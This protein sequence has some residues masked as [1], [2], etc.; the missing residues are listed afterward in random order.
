MHM[1]PVK[2]G[3]GNNNPIFFMT[4]QFIETSDKTL[5]EVNKKVCMCFFVEYHI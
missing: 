3:I 2:P 4:K 5:K 1:N